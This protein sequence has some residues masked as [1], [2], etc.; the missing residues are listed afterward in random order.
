MSQISTP[1]FLYK[2]NDTGLA[3]FDCELLY[4]LIYLMGKSIS[5]RDKL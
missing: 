2:R 4:A 3:I 1:S 5:D